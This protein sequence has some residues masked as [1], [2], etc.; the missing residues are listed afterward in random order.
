MKEMFKI[1][2]AIRVVYYMVVA[3]AVYIMSFELEWKT[4][5]AIT[6]LIVVINAK[7]FISTKIDEIIKGENAKKD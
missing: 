4:I 2:M 5:V 6:M 3:I 1:K 7:V